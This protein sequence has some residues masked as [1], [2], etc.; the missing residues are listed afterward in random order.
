[1]GTGIF[2]PSSTDNNFND[3]SGAIVQLKE[4]VKLSDLLRFY[5]VIRV[6]ES[7]QVLCVFHRDSVA[8]AHYYPE[9]DLYHCFTCNKSWDLVDFF[10]EKENISVFEAVVRLGALFS[11]DLSKFKSSADAYTSKFYRILNEAKK[12]NRPPSSGRALKSLNEAIGKFYNYPWNR[13]F[14]DYAINMLD[15]YNEDFI[16][17]SNEEATIVFD[18]V[19][20]AFRYLSK[21]N[22]KIEEMV[23]EGNLCAE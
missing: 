3:L 6:A 21:T 9:Q 2:V 5:R 1:M 18:R 12:R 14:R 11:V 16:D 15:Y 23:S 13:G 17:M 4:S 19:K 22:S 20:N 10:R 8:S 7:Q